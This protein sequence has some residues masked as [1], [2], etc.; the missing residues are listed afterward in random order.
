MSTDAGGVRLWNTYGEWRERSKQDNAEVPYIALPL[1]KHA[2]LVA[3]LGN[4]AKVT[5]ARCESL[6]SQDYTP[7]G[8]H[9]PECM[10]DDI[11]LDDI[12][13]ALAALG[14]PQ[15]RDEGRG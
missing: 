12:D 10:A 6:C 13:A 3:L 14:G 15:G 4:A 1:A 7:R 2:E 9:S 11:D 8:R 5:R